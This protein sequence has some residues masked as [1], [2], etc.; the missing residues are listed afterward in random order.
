MKNNTKTSGYSATTYSLL[1][2]SEEKERNIAEAIV[3]LLFIVCAIFS[4]WQAGQQPFTVRIG[5]L[6]HS[7]P[8]AQAAA[9]RAA[10]A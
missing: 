4:I 7:A 5:G 2:R 10:R 6:T 1:I 3:Y 8:V 9:P